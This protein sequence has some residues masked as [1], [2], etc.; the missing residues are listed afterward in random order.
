MAYFDPEKKE[1]RV[2]NRL[3]KRT[4][5]KERRADR[6]KAGASEWLRRTRLQAEQEA[7]KPPSEAEIRQAADA[8]TTQAGGVAQVAAGELAQL[9]MGGESGRMIEAARGTTE[10]LGE[11]AAQASLSSRD[12][13]NQIYMNEKNALEDRLAQANQWKMNYDQQLLSNII[14]LGTKAVAAGGAVITA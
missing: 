11:T 1:S 10:G 14:N 2:A 6:G 7:L 5:R 13:A 9:G 8:A 3:E 4:S 12:L